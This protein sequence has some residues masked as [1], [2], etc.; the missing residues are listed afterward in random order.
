MT[1]DFSNKSVNQALQY[2]HL[3]LNMFCVNQ[4]VTLRNAMTQH[5]LN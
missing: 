4:F 1:L 2:Y 3:V 5:A